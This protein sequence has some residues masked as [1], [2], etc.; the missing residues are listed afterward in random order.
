VAAF[1]KFAMQ[2]RLEVR[3]ADVGLSL[4]R[5]RFTRPLWVL[6]AAVGLALLAACTNVANLLLA[7]AARREKEIALR[8]AL[9]ATRGRLIRQALTESL[10]LAGAGCVCGVLFAAWAQRALIGML[11]VQATL[12]IAAIPEPAVLAFTVGI[13]VLGALVFG[14]TPALRRGVSRFRRPLVVAQVAFSV[15]LVVLAGLFG[16]TLAA[17]DSIDLGFHGDHTMSLQLDFPN[18][19]TDS[20]ARAAREQFLSAA[21]HLPGVASVSYGF[22]SPFQGAYSSAT[23]HVPGAESATIDL[24]TIG[25]RYFETLAAPLKRGRE[26]EP[27]DTDKSRRV[28]MVNESFARRYFAGDP[29]GQAISFDGVEQ[30]WIVGV[31]PD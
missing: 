21:E 17:I 3:E 18:S 12:P 9:G 11:P 13:S 19:W 7:R 1:R 15:V 31:A 10:L 25:P 4:W 28:V 2:Q 29:V 6:M 5:D 27:G 23:V 8:I 24:A 22:P 16:R 20:Q 14:L 30:R 26:F